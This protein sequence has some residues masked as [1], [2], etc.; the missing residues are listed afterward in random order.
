MLGCVTSEDSEGASDSSMNFD[1]DRKTLHHSNITVISTRNNSVDNHL[2]LSLG[3]DN[4]FML[5]LCC[6]YTEHNIN[7]NTCLLT[8]K[9][10]H[11]ND[12][13]STM[14]LWLTWSQVDSASKV[15]LVKEGLTASC[16]L[17]D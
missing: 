1:S 13:G 4:I 2:Y 9:T 6:A 10:M 15:V 12:F 17:T 11:R 14:V 5:A 8:C 7:T 3:V 16:Q